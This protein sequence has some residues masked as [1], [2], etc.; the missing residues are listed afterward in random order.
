MKNKI[1]LTLIAMVGLS[2]LA[3]A[4]S[5]RG[6]HRN[7]YDSVSKEL[8]LTDEQRTQMQ[9]LHLNMKAE[10]QTAHKTHQAEMES[11]FNNPKFDDQK[12]KKLIQQDRDD[13][14][15]RKMKH[16]HSMYQ[17]LTPD[18]RNQHS[19]MIQNHGH[20]MKDQKN[21]HHNK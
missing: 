21:K 20:K 19:Q 6:E 11:F 2:G 8:K 7:H 4:E 13:R 9:S 10:N 3:M 1:A 12:A 14:S 15:I 18:Q 16:R 17:I 5:N